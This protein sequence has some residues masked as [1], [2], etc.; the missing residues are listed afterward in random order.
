[1]LTLDHV[2]VSAGTLEAGADATE[3]ALGLVLE[4]GGVHPD[5]GTHNRL[6]G[7]GAEY[8]E[9]ISIDPVAPS[10][11]RARWFDLDHF[12]GPPRLTNWILRTA[13]LEAALAALGPEFGTPV[14]L[15]RGDLRWRMAVPETGLLPFD[16]CAPALIEWETEAPV[17]RLAARGGALEALTVT[18][19]D[20]ERLAA[21]LSP[22]LA[23]HR[24][25]YR[26]GLPGLSAQI[27]TPQG[28]RH[29]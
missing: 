28:V 15:R 20:A 4:A 14:A 18:H 22:H 12:A 24:V 23:D 11:G 17:A 1:M 27:S 5:F 25:T 26:V 19:P 9:V 8:L 21:L 10:P 29:L 3:R 13:S 16:N 6:L 7:L 2:A